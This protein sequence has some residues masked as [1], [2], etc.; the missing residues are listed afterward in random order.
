MTRAL[1]ISVVWIAA[2]AAVVFGIWTTE[3][4]GCLWALLIPL[5]ATGAICGG[6]EVGVS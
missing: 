5:L 3:S 4:A 2:S 1:A 6:V